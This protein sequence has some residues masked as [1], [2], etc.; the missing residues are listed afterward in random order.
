MTSYD[1]CLAWNWEHDAGFV[2]VL[3]LSCQRRGLSLLQIT[4]CNLTYISEGLGS[5]KLGFSTFLDRSS[6]DD[7]RFFSIVEWAQRHT[8]YSINS[9]EMARR[10]WDKAAMHLCL[11]PIMQTPYTIILPSYH[12]Q[13]LLP[14]VDLSPLGNSFTIKPAHG[15]SG[16]GVVV[17]AYSMDQILLA[18]QEYPSDKY[19]LQ[20]RIIPARLGK[21]AAWFRVIYSAGE[22]YPCWWDT[23][24]HLY[25]PLTAAE[26]SHYH[27]SPL[28]TI[29]QSIAEI[30]G[31]QLFSS[32]IAL[33]AE[34]LFVVVDYVNDPVD[35]RLQSK[36]PEGVPDDIVHFIADTLA[37][38]A[39]NHR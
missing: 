21:R 20:N 6:E 34:G 12:E 30:C 37:T 23:K 19:L 4:P 2:N 24:T 29:I 36:S 8:V 38:L 7:N 18:R 25:T 39:K 3:D 27:L 9:Y 26:E 5:R 13:P 15:G 14:P 33:T 31:L 22:I 10:T 35:L 11:F 28:Q 1:L 32:E 16:A 17:E